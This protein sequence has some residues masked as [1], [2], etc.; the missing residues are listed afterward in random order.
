MW[1]PTLLTLV[2]PSCIVAPI[3]DSEN[4]FFSKSVTT[5]TTKKISITRF[6]SMDVDNVHRGSPDNY[7][8]VR[9]LTKY[10]ANPSSLDIILTRIITLSD[11]RCYSNIS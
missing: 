9:G 11:K 5:T 3:R 4:K 7:D 1:H 8:D 10:L 6:E 2:P